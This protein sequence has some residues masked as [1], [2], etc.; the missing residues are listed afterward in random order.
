MASALRWGEERTLLSINQSVPQT[1]AV[2]I[3]CQIQVTCWSSL[4]L[5]VFSLIY[6]ILF[7]LK[8]KITA[9]H[10]QLTVQ[11]SVV[12]RQAQMAPLEVDAT[13][14]C[15]GDFKSPTAWDCLSWSADVNLSGCDK[16]TS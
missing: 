1:L 10:P 9:E 3:S 2:S 6:F 14:K 15:S 16:C 13:T 11:G 7:Y 12:L 8:G 5:V 4:A